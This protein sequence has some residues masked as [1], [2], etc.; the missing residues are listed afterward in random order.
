MAIPPPSS[1]SPSPATPPNETA[2]EMYTRHHDEL[3]KMRGEM[4]D[5]LEQLGPAPSPRNFQRRR[6][7]MN[8]QGI[9]C[10]HSQVIVGSLLA[11]TCIT[12]LVL[13]ILLKT[14]NL[15]S[16]PTPFQTKVWSYSL[17]SVGGVAAISSIIASRSKCCGK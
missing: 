4:E 10:S 14:G 6:K 1:A 3:K 9:N 11:A 13:A 8:C 5:V 16:N 12:T 15:M 7:Y 17:L 2:A